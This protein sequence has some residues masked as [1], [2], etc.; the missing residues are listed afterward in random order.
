MKQ[1]DT[2]KQRFAENKSFVIDTGVTVDPI[3]G[4]I[5]LRLRESVDGPIWQKTKTKIANRIWLTKHY[6]RMVNTQVQEEETI[7]D[8]S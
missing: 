4:N 7:S 5:F 6:A 3:W 2:E 8:Q 1:I